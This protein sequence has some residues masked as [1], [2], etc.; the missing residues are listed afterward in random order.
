[1]FPSQGGPPSG[2]D[3]SEEGCDG[4]VDLSATG[5]GNKCIGDVGGGYVRPLSPEYHHPLYHH[6]ANT[7]DIYYGGEMAGGEGVYGIVV[8][9]R[10]RPSSGRDGYRYRD[11]YVEGGGG[12]R[13]R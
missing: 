12:V 4:Q 8:A 2:K 11:G 7:G 3:T 9:G 10:H 1:M 13:R 5:C 6:S